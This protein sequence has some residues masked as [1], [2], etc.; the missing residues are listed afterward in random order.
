MVR[1]QT[2]ETNEMFGIDGSSSILSWNTYTYV[3]VS[4][5]R[6]EQEE[7]I[8]F[9]WPR[10]LRRFRAEFRVTNRV[11]LKESWIYNPLYGR[12]QKWHRRTKFRANAIHNQSRRIRAT[13]SHQLVHHEVERA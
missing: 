2:S 4:V 13:F 1:F 11:Y 12:R 7:R 10:N 3:Y 9:N 5:T 6:I 8:E